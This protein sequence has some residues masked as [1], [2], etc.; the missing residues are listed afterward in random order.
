MVLPNLYWGLARCRIGGALAAALSCPDHKPSTETDHRGERSH[1]VSSR[2]LLASA[3]SN[4]PQL[5][6]MLLW[7]YTETWC[8][9]DDG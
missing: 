2:A 5:S 1:I 3:R 4:E 7:H 8:M 9:M 6:F